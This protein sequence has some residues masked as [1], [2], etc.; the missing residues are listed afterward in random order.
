M[1]EHTPGPWTLGPW[2]SGP[3]EVHGTPVIDKNTL[4]LAIASN[5]EADA[6]LIAAAPDL[7]AALEALC[8]AP[9]VPDVYSDLW[10]DANAALDKAKGTDVGA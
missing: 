2:N 9:A 4:I 7:L 8:D 6:R 10:G 5:N 3:H 1:S